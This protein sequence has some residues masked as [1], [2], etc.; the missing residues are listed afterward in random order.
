MK[1]LIY[2]GCFVVLSVIQT[3]IR[4]AGII[5]G[6]VPTVLLWSLTYWIAKNLS[7]AWEA[8]HGTNT[9][10]QH[11]E[12]AISPEEPEEL[13]GPDIPLSVFVPV[14]GIVFV[15]ILAIIIIFE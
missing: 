5:L 10:E 7:K 15:V 2:F 12:P 9:E 11:C 14:L 6:G 3:L 1:F 4:N 8:K 13:P